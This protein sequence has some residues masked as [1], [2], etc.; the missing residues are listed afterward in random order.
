[1]SRY[2]AILLDAGGTLWSW[3][4]T[5]GQV[6]RDAL[7]SLG[8]EVPLS[9]AEAADRSVAERFRPELHAL[10]TSGT[11]S[12]PD[13]IEALLVR[14]TAEMKKELGLAVDE[15][16]LHR[17]AGRGFEGV[18]DLYS[19]TKPVLEELHGA[20]KLAIVSNGLNQARVSRRLGIGHYFEE[21]IGSWHVGLKKPMPQIFH[22]GLAAVGGSPDEAVMVGDTWGPDIEGAEAVGIKAIHIVR[23]GQ[24]SPSPDAITDLW[25]LVRFLKR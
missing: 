23:D 16:A 5:G 11:P 14:S 1:M 6:W 12:G 7:S 24:P 22:M 2:K 8:V 21:I 17:A 10:E 25:G 18:Q 3:P 20:Y 4:V 15:T 19:D 9:E 13:A